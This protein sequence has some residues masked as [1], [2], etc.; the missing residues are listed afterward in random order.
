MGPLQ[1]LKVLEMAGI[2]PGPFCAMM[3]AD[4]GAE[5]VRID[6]L[7]QKGTGHRANVLNRG[8]RS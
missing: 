1:G 3:L 2:G 8:R 7:T 4:M 5:V 6:R